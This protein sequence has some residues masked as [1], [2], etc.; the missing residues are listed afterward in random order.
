MVKYKDVRA[1]VLEELAD[2]EWH[3]TK[4]LH[5]KCE[6]L[7]LNFNGNKGPL[8]NVLHQLKK[9]RILESSGTGDY[10]LLTDNTTL[11]SSPNT[12][13][14]KAELQPSIK[15]IESYITKYKKFDWI[16]CSNQELLAARNNVSILLALSRKISNEFE[17]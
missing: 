7:G 6:S 17:R 2:Q 5:D 10:R 16:N 12:K 11:N 13:E 4:N 3:T 14:K 9:K 8:Y 1:I 15:I